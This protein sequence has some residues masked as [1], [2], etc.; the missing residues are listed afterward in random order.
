MA[1]GDALE[2]LIDQYLAACG[3]ARNR[4]K[5]AAP[6]PR[7]TV[8]LENI[9][10]AQLFDYEHEHFL[11]DAPFQLEIQLLQRLYHWEH[12]DDDTALTP[13]L[14]SE[15]GYY[16][17]YT[18]LDMPVRHE[19][20]GVPHI[21][22]DHPL[23]RDPDLGLLRRHDFTS[24]G[25]MPQVIRVWEQMTELAGDRLS[26]GFHEWHRGPLDM[27]IQLRGY[28][29]FVA[30]TVERPQFVHDLMR[31]LV[32]ERI[33]WWEA[34]TQFLGTK[35]EA[36]GISDD[37]VNVPFISPAMFEDFCLPRYLELEQYH[38]AV[39][40]FHSCGNKAP[41]AHLVMRIASLDRFEVNH[42]TPL[43]EMLAAVPDDKWIDYS[44]QN[45]DVLLGSE[46][47]QEAKMQ[48]V[49][50]ACRGR[51]YTLCGQALQRISEDYAVDMAQIK[52]FIRA[53]RRVLGRDPL[54]EA[55]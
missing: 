43:E 3:S 41:L 15:A 38:G 28:D 22:D 53:A 35:P 11:T 44:F 32:E 42:W 10:W 23:T 4:A 25:Q 21:R 31:F 39:N 40:R 30:D 52:Q 6:E 26:I 29:S 55:G 16:P 51:R 49:V 46:E 13:Q 18:V 1:P 54:P 8:Y 24:S 20:V 9:G 47:E 36:V 27:A 48:S 14:K 37:W 17:E 12:F 50:D 7:F 2:Q 19:R 45:L 34:R 5:A 33:R